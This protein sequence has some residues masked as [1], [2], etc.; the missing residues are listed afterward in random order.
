[1]YQT[2]GEIVSSAQETGNFV[3]RSFPGLGIRI[4]REDHQGS[5]VDVDPGAE[6]EIILYG[7]QLDEVSGYLKRPELDYKF[8]LGDTQ[9]SEHCVQHY[10]TG[11]RGSYDENIGSLYVVGRIVGEETMVKV[12]GVRVEL[13][14]IENAVIDDFDSEE[15]PQCPVVLDCMAKALPI[16][17]NNN[18]NEI[19]S[20]C[21]LSDSVRKEVG[22][23]EKDGSAAFVVSGS[24]LLVL[25]Q[26]RCADKLKHACMPRAFLVIPR[27]PLSPTGKR[28]R[29]GL[30]KLESSKQLRIEDQNS[31]PLSKHG[32]AG[33]KVAEVLTEFLNLH[34]SQESILT[35]TA[36]FAMV[37]G[38]SM[39]AVRVTRALYAFHNNVQ[40]N[41]FLGGEFGK[42]V[43]PFDV[44][45]LLRSENLGAYVQMLD[46]QNLCRPKER[47]LIDETKKVESPIAATVKPSSFNDLRRSSLY[48]ALFQA[49]TLGQSSIAAGLL[50]VGAD[51]NYGSHT[52][53]L[54][55]VTHRLQQRA[56]FRSSPL[57]IACSR[58]D[59]HLVKRLLDKEAKFNSPDASGYFPLHLASSGSRVGLLSE[60]KRICC[61]QHLLLAGAPLAM[62][63]GNKQSVLHCA[64]RTGH[65][66]LLKYIM[67]TWNKT[68]DSGTSM[69]NDKHFFN[70]RDRWMRK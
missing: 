62:R 66:E 67:D 27:L 61:V 28:D 58:G 25:L 31:L 20:Y 9:Q 51:P 57:H 5:L 16:G 55:K 1:M 40:N 19:R 6:G 14:E 37:G 13:G 54:G 12:N 70:W 7:S 35:T 36:T 50:S 53:R 26:A 44:V 33:S 38:D 15:H 48:D 32:V 43:G 8:V 59:D 47:D 22:I 56:Q 23:P 63:D 49:T 18:G 60:V 30:P 21:V 41:R 46:S 34:P 29:S 68:N 17:T 39:A 3:G 45:N 2:C 4:C 42:L 64:A 65:S 24:P 10:R 11:D 52:G 69:I